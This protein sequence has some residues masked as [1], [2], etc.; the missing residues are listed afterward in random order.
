MRE[1]MHAARARA[2]WRSHLAGVPVLHLREVSRCRAAFIC[3]VP[4]FVFPFALVVHS[5]LFCDGNLAGGPAP[6]HL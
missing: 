6:Y 3:E 5:R 4:A 1:C 2:L